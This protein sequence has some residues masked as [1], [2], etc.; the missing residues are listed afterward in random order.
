MP[1]KYK[2]LTEAQ[3]EHFLEK[4]CV[5]LNDCF[6]RDMAEEWKALAYKRM[7]DY[8]PD[9][10]TTWKEARVHLPEIKSVPIREAAPKAFDA[11]CDLLGGEER[12]A[13]KYPWKKTEEDGLD[14]RDGFI[15]NFKMGAD[16]P[17]DPPSPKSGETGWHKDGDMFKHFLDSPEQGLL[18]I[19]MWSDIYP[20]S[21]GTFIACD[22][23][24]HFAQRLSEH[25]EG[26]M[27]GSFGDLI[28][29]CEDFV[30]ITGNIGDVVLAH[31]Y[32]LHNASQNLSGRPRFI[33][34]RPISLK[35]PMNFNREDPDEFSPVELGILR[36]LGLERLDFK[37]TTPREGLMPEREI[38]AMK[39]LAEQKARLGIA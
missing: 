12:V 21:G 32:M 14:L 27:P 4:G 23:I 2:V 36:A 29:K 15:I 8:D 24:K 25:P 26:L 28:D 7:V 13:R 20:Q 17:W 18:T 39:V 19:V 22:S 34:N 30:E 6:S 9:D 5:V 38:M 3:I 10:P 11:I 16:R 35:E 37:I 31:P 1:R 33:T